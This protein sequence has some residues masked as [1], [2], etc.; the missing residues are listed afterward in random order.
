MTMMKSLGPLC[1]S[2]VLLLQFLQK[3]PDGLHPSGEK[4]EE[5][6]P[7]LKRFPR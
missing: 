6:G 4:E 7:S 2:D 5:A 1:A 3:Y